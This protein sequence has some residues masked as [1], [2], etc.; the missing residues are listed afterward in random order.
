MLGPSTGLNAELYHGPLLARWQLLLLM[1]SP[2][3][4]ISHSCFFTA[5]ESEESR[6]SLADDPLDAHLLTC[7]FR[8]FME[9]GLPEAAAA[10]AAAALTDGSASGRSSSTALVADGQDA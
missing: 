9:R 3:D 10:A 7:L 8:R 4:R 2:A 1:P 6:R 5:E